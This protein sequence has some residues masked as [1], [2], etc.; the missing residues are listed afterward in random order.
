MNHHEIAVSL[1]IMGFEYT[2]E[3]MSEMLRTKPSGTWIKGDAVS[4]GSSIKNDDN[5][6]YID[7]NL[8]SRHLLEQHVSDIYERIKH[9]IS[10]FK[11]VGE[12]CSLELSCCIYFSD[13]IPEI[14]FSKEALAFLATIQCEIDLDLYQL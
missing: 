9:N 11:K 4:H 2:V 3:E 7:S 13:D 12:F 8:G 6:W 14:H 1:K 10:G 5:G